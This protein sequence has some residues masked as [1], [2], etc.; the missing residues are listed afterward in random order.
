MRPEH[1]SAGAAALLAVRGQNFQT[2]PNGQNGLSHPHANPAIPGHQHLGTCP[3]GP[4]GTTATHQ[5]TGLPT[6]VGNQQIETTTF[7][8][9]PSESQL[10]NALARYPDLLQA[11]E[12][13]TWQA[14]TSSVTLPRV[15][16]MVSLL[17]LG[18]RLPSIVALWSHSG[19]LQVFARCS[20]KVYEL[21]KDGAL[22]SIDEIRKVKDLTKESYDALKQRIGALR[23][24]HNPSGNI[25]NEERAQLGKQLQEIAQ[26]L[27]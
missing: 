8:E 13:K 19:A 7:I 12:L 26:A 25:G 5:Q 24:G 11:V 3:V 4:T 6:D 14:V 1:F 20:G 16:L 10:R 17:V 18:V 22:R 27:Q 23:A 15:A 21:L 2:P 9:A